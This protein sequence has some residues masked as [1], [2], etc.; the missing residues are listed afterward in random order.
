MALMS[1]LTVILVLVL[2]GALVLYLTGKEIAFVGMRLSGAQSLNIAEGG[3]VSARSALMALFNADPI[4]VTRLDSSVN[5]PMLFNWWASGVAVQQNPLALLDYL[6]LEGQQ[7][8]IGATPGTPSVTFHVN[9]GLGARWKLQVASGAPPANPLGAGTY[10]ATLVLSPR[11]VRPTVPLAC[12]AAGAPCAIHRLAIDEYEFFF[13]YEII[14]DG[15]MNPQARR[16]IRFTQDFSVTVNRQS[17]ARY[18]L[19]THVH[20]T[21]NDRDIWFTSR[22]CFDGPVHT[23]GEFRFAF[24][25]QFTD[26]LT[27]AGVASGSP[28]GSAWAWFNNAGGSPRPLRLEENENVREGTR[29]R[30]DAPLVP[31]G[32]ACGGGLGDPQAMSPAKFTRGVKVIPY[33]ENF[34]SQKGVS[35]GR[36]PADTSMVT[37][38][39]IRQ[40]I[41]ELAN[42]STPVPSG[43]YIPRNG[44]LAGA[45]LSGGIY[46][47]GD[48]T[49]LTLS[50]TGS[51][52]EIARYVLVQGS[53]RVTIDINRLTQQTTIT[54]TGGTVGDGPGW[55]D[56][57]T[58]TFVGVPKGW[59]GTANVNAAI[60]FVEGN[61]LSLSGTLEEKEQTLIAASGRIDITDHIRYES[62]PDTADPTSNPLNI[63]GLYAATNDIRIRTSAPNNLVLHAVMMAGMVGDVPP[64]NSSVFVE[65]YNSGAPRGTVRLI[66][67]LIEEYYGAFGTFNRETGAPETGYGRDFRFDRRLLRGFSPPYFPTTGLFQVETGSEALAGARP[68]WREAAP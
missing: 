38:A 47:Q 13:Q 1:V 42:N 36:D 48:L 29:Q 62:P 21:P 11:N 18:L 22:T 15:R 43:I 40:A 4:G 68:V 55:A 51:S 6:V 23:N 57:Q 14:S 54:N 60:F 45:A 20:R 25:P 17:F 9:W 64:Y 24:F 12:G 63:L 59:Q 33:P 19:F 26:A 27:S 37:N 32:G 34:Y 50:V 5:E 49:S 56:P 7:F 41:P 46:V 52:T 66:G 31:V 58:R 28:S 53:Q 30:V 39:Q 67:G 44:A 61:I 10:A 35:I 2:V 65:N 3:A 8:S 16:Q